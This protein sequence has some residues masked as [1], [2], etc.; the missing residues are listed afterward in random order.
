VLVASI[1][2][3]FPAIFANA[4]PSGNVTA[5]I[6]T[7]PPTSPLGLASWNGGF[8]QINFTPVTAGGI[9]PWGKDVN[10]LFQATTAWEQWFQAGAPVGYD[11]TFSGA[12]S[13]Y[14]LG[15]IIASATGPGLGWLS[16]TD[17]NVTDPDA[18][19]G[20][21]SPVLHVASSARAGAGIAA[22]YSYAGNP[23]GS[24][25]GTAATTTSPPDM[26]WDTLHAA[27]WA[28][29]VSGNAAAAVWV[30]IS[31]APGT[32]AAHTVILGTGNTGFNATGPGTSGYPLLSGGASADPAFSQL[33]LAGS[34]I[35]GTLGPGNGGL[36]V[37][38]PTA[39]AVLVGNGA[40]AVQTISGTT[41]LPLLAGSPPAFAQVSINTGTT[42]TLNNQRMQR[43]GASFTS[44]TLYDV[45]AGVG[46]IRYRL[47]GDGGG[48]GWALASGVG[49]CGGGGGYTEG[50]LAVTPGETLTI[51]IG[52]GGAGG[53]SGTTTGG[54]GSG[55]SLAGSGFSTITCAGGGGG[56]TF[57]GAG[58]GAGGTV[59]NANGPLLAVAGNPG[60]T[61][62]YQGG[63]DNGLFVTAGGGGTFGVSNTQPGSG[64]PGGTGNFP[65]GGGNGGAGTSFTSY[66]GGNGATGCLVLEW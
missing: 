26:V 22:V 54:T 38:D 7:T 14:P 51:T 32:Y 19:G 60:G 55:S 43:G 50:Y 61:F 5:P 27:L 18:G 6:P 65:G 24:V 46:T 41:G 33:N 63:P 25:A 15:A 66:N 4:A 49:Y 52:A 23:N 28:C 11:A 47:W 64:G 48:G 3:R 13:G 29:V 20:G 30:S 21:W 17:A 35:T 12:V 8:Q 42:G 62:W 45:P 2:I 16:T 1:P 31:Y 59:T 9:P 10:G 53:T 34:G 57:G 44:S 36:G 56:S 37:A 40:S 58:S 39:N